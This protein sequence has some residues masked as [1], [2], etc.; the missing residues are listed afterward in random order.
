MS[1]SQLLIKREQTP[2]VAILKCAGRIVRGAEIHILKSAVTGLR[3]MRV[4]VLDLSSVEALDCGGL[5]M[6]VLL[7][8][9]TRSNGIQLKIVNPSKFASEMFERTGLTRVLHISSLDDAV[10]VQRRSDNSV[11]NVSSAG[12]R[13]LA[14]Q[15]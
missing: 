4:I 11:V 15:V 14:A 10:D 1:Q 6:L 12:N 2:D 13:P 7:Q 8:C 3:K 9:W 5:G